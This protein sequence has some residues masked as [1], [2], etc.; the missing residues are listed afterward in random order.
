MRVSMKMAALVVVLSMGCRGAKKA[1]DHAETQGFAV[2]ARSAG[3]E[4]FAE[5]Q[6]LVAGAVSTSHTHV[7]VLDGF[8]PLKEGTVAAVLRGT[9]GEQ[10]FA[11]DQPKRDGIYPIDL[12]PAKEGLFDL[13]FRVTV[14]DRTEEIHAGQVRVGTSSEPGG[15]A[16]EARGTGEAPAADAGTVSFLKEQQ[17]RT[18]FAT[19]PVSEG[20]WHDSVR[21]SARV[22][23]AA[24]GSVVLTASLEATVMPKPWPHVGKDVARGDAVFRLLPR[25]S[26]RSIRDLEADGA[27]LEAQVGVARKRVERLT[28]LLRVEA[29]S[30][31]EL[32]RARA[33]LLGMEARL[34]GTRRDLE[35]ATMAT[36][37]GGTKIALRAPWSGRVAEVAVSPGQSVAPGVALARLVRLRPVWLE[38][39][40]RPENAARVTGTVAGLHL[41][42][43]GGG[44]AIVVPA[45][46]VRLV[47]RAPEV[48]ARTATVAVILELD[49]SAMD[50]PIGSAFEAEV[51]LGG[52]KKGLVIPTTAL[53]DD[54]GMPVVYLQGEGESFARREV[55]VVARQ[56][57]SSVVEGLVPGERL[58]T[59]GGGAI[60]RAALLSSGAPEGHVH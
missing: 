58:V 59:V 39:A 22:T 50:L 1:E 49:R 42:R 44:E 7:T 9:G 41:E 18:T 48:D 51:L 6:P 3:Y 57:A 35:A 26:S 24:G 56:G 13:L 20:V 28:E 14:G 37:G 36:A 11:L 32:E 29:T 40:L 60:R 34:S 55:K 53:V 46:A 52:E 10:V 54:A 21:G 23:A 19:A 2:T 30:A 17:W 27:S 25:S 8:A 16:P 33:E 47:S 15:L 12:K 45:G 4:V 38:V 31:A 43:P 5:T